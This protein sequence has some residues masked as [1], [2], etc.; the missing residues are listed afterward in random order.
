MPQWTQY[1][2]IPGVKL[3]GFAEDSETGQPLLQFFLMVSHDGL[4][5]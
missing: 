3:A 5:A 1:L 4:K 2:G